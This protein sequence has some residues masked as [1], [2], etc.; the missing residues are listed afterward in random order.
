RHLGWRDFESFCALFFRARGY[1]VKENLTLRKPRAQIDLVAIGPS[2][3]FCVDCKRWKKGH[4]PAVLQKFATAQKKRSSLLRKVL[5]DPRP[6]LSVILSLS[7]PSGDFVDGV[8]V[9][10]IGS[11]TGFLD[12]VEAYLDRLDA[13]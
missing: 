7:A 12:S 9:V 3:A 4:S 6:I 13:S 1:E 8:A 10:P 11:L 5:K 2:Y